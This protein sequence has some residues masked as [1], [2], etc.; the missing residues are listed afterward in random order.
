MTTRK[1]DYGHENRVGQYPAVGSKLDELSRYRRK[2]D[3][4]FNLAGKSLGY[5]NQISDTFGAVYCEINN[6]K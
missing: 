6:N 1:L 3:E 5:F 4:A 2:I